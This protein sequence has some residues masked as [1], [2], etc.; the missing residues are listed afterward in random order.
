MMKRILTLAAFMVMMLASAN[1]QQLEAMIPQ[2]PLDPAVRMGKLDNGLT[3]YIRHNEWPEQ[4]ADFYIAQKVGSIMEDDNQ[5]G[6]AHFL[7]HMCFNGTTNFP[8]DGLKSYLETIGVKF[9]EDLN[10]YTSFDETV[11]NINNVPVISNPQAIDSCLLILH[12]WSHDLLLEEKEIDKERGV[13]NEEWRMRSSATQRMYEKGFPEVYEGSKYANRM[14]IGTMDIVMNFPYDDLRNYYKKWYRPDLQGI[15]VVGDVDVDAI[16]AKI[17]TIFADIKPVENPAEREYFQVPDNDQPI[18]SIQKDKEQQMSMVY[19][20]WKHDA[21]SRDMKNTMMQY[22]QSYTTNAINSM[23]SMRFNEISQKPNPP[24]LGAQISYNED[25]LV[26]KTKDACMG[27]T[28]FKDNG[29][30]DAI[31]ALYREL[32]RARRFGFTQTEYDRFKENFK[33]SI[34]AMYERR[35]KVQNSS[36]VDEYVRHFLDNVAAP[37]IEWEHTNMIALA[38]QIPLEVV[39]QIIMQEEKCAPVVFGMFPEKEGISYPTDEEIIGILKAVEAEEIEAY[40]EEVSNEPLLDVSQL[41]GSKIKSESESHFGFTKLTLQNGINI[42][43]KK[44]DFTPNSISMHAESFGGISLYDKSEHIQLN[45]V[46]LAQIG[47]YANFST[48]QLNKMLAG[49]KVSV[50]PS[51]GYRDESMG[52]SCVVKDFETMLQLAYLAFTAPRKDMDAYTATIQ[53]SREQLAAAEIKPTTALNDTITSVIYNN[54]PFRL[55]EK[56]EDLDKIN[57]DRI[58]QIYKERF[59]DADD[60]QFFFIGDI[61]IEAAKP[62]FEKYLGSLPVVKGS[63]KYKD[64]DLRIRKGEVENIFEKEQETPNAIVV[65]LYHAPMDYT[66]KNDLCVDMLK[67]ILQIRFTES[68]REDNGGAY[69]VGVGSGL[70]DYPEKFGMIQI[71]LPTAPEKREAMTKV[72]YQGIDNMVA[73]GPKDEDLQKVKEYMLRSYEESVKQNGYWLG[74]INEKVMFDRDFVTDYKAT[75]EAI[76]TADIQQVAKKIFKSGN[77]LE[78]GMTTPTK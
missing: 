69:S 73:N 39:N 51:I 4:R 19:I 54:H 72:I 5:R 24:F 12:D 28:M 60:F 63:E 6:L 59:A 27:V 64:I 31:S 36:Y 37:G 13:I 14:P 25:Y 48:I 38:D 74:A 57:Y 76:T 42:Y 3:Y 11:Y 71:Q 53:R 68:V 16:E 30:K 33:S 15:I 21:M 1:A 29:H 18:V 17:K 47:G 67:Q 43:V 58:L 41:K 45:N 52:G 56:P 75:V 49:K 77:R 8:G 61:D 2:L 50:S 70:S 62:L 65:Y 10:A 78:I 22:V 23:L 9:G 7:E 32:L 34:E 35:D 55:R 20:M 26:S 46:S 44:T 66:L 40:A